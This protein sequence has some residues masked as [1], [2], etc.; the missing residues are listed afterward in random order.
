[1]GRQKSAEGIVGPSTGLK[2]RTCNMGQESRTS[3]TTGDTDYRAAMPDAVSENS[4]RN[5]RGYET[6]VSN[7]TAKRE[8]LCP[9]AQQMMEAVVERENMTVALRRVMANKGSSGY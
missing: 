5:L 6:G 2:A 7:V 3:M 4:R 1:M 8:Q 9:E